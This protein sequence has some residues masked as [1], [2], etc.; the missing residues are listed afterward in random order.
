L[1]FFS[2][3]TF[4]PIALQSQLLPFGTLSNTEI[5]ENTL[6]TN[7]N[8]VKMQFLRYPYLIL[9]PLTEWNG[10]KLSSIL[11]IACTKI[12][13]VSMRG[14][15]KDFID[16]YFL[17][18]QF[19]LP[20]LIE[21]ITQKYHG[22]DYNTTHLLKSLVYFVDADQQPMPRMHQDVAWDHIKTEIIRQVKEIKYS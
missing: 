4:D 1:D 10:I 2:K 20:D 7:I 11:D 5:A 19:T 22:I 21:K 3:D 8:S 14:S 12:I 18:K 17:L 9:E 13:T 6:N 16:V 15:K